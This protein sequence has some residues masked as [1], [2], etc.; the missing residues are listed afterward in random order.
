LGADNVV[1]LSSRRDDRVFPAAQNGAHERMHRTLKAETA[2]PPEP[3]ME[4]QQ[5]RF[6]DF[7]RIYKEE[8]PH[9]ALG[10]KRPATSYRP[11]PRPYPATLPPIEYAGHLEKRKIEHNGMMCWKNGRIFM[12]KTLCGEYV[13]LE[14]IDDGIW[15]V[16]YGPVLLA[17][18]DEREMKFYG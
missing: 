14:E 6:D 12:S 8:R 7:R 13:G 3:T 1:P 17:R 5:K 16:Y 11:S 4:R 10:Q 2:R 18:F 9:E 15:S